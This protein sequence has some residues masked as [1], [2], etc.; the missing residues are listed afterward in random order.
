MENVSKCALAAAALALLLS[1]PN[2]RAAAS[3]ASHLAYLTGFPDGTVRPEA[4][5]TREQL[6]QAL[7]RL[8][9]EAARED[10][11]APT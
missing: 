8:L 5:L 9:Q 2:A 4:P 1:L 6:A 3:E 10:L 7:W 11:T